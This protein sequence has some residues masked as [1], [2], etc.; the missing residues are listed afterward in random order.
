MHFIVIHGKRAE[1]NHQWLP[2]W[3]GINA[4]LRRELEDHLREKLVG[5]VV[6][7]ALYERAD[8]LVLAWLSARFPDLDGL[9]DYLE[10]L[11][12][13]RPKGGERATS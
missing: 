8:E 3:L 10:G 9:G 2:T 6:D 1:L 7:E 5:M 4:H 11:K 12:F 13:V